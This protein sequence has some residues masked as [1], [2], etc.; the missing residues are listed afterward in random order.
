M[1]NNYEQAPCTKSCCVFISS[2][3]FRARKDI[4]ETRHPLDVDLSRYCVSDAISTFASAQV[5]L[6]KDKT[7]YHFVTSNRDRIGLSLGVCENLVL[8]L[9]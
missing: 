2:I 1:A 4:L 8:S 3:N 6:N 5:P 9:V 7:D